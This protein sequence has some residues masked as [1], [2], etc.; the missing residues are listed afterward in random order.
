M[1]F[2]KHN[3]TPREQTVCSI[4]NRIPNMGSFVNVGFRQWHDPRSH[5]WINICNA[6]NIDWSIVEV[7]DKNVQE[8]LEAGCPESKIHH[9]NITDVDN[10][11]EADALLFWHGP[12][13]LLKEDFLAILPELEKK[14]KTLIFGMP[15]GDHPQGVT[16][17]N[18]HEEHISEWHTPEWEDLGYKVIEVW[19][20]Q[21]HPHITAYKISI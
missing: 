21:P 16:H 19:D 10:L 8:S 17:G 18:I 6:N 7:F 9:M 4:F 12:E 20:N 1:N 11:P 13:H 5:W 15:L 2:P 3:Y 14:Y